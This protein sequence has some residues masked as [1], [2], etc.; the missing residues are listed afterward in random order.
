MQTASISGRSTSN[1]NLCLHSL[2][3][4]GSSR[5]FPAQAFIMLEKGEAFAP[6]L[7]RATALTNFHRTPA[8]MLWDSTS[9]LRGIINMSFARYVLIAAFLGCP[10]ASFAQQ[11][12]PPFL[13][14][15]RLPP[16]DIPGIE[17][18]PVIM[19][20]DSSALLL[21]IDRLEGQLRS[22]TGQM[23]QMQFQQRKL[24]EAIRKMQETGQAA[25]LDPAKP[26]SRPL[27]GKRPGDAFDPAQNPNAPGAPRPLGQPYG[28][29]PAPGAPSAPAP[30]LPPKPALPQGPIA[31][32][33]NDPN[34]P[35][36]INGGGAGRPPQPGIA[37]PVIPVPLVPNAPAPGQQAQVPLAPLPADD[38]DQG[39][40]L[41]KQGQYAAAE[42]RLNAFLQKN[43][44]DRL[45]PEA[46]FNL[47]ETF[48]QRQRHREAAEQFLK[49]STD[50]SKSP[51]APDGLVR[52][53]MSL[54]AMG[55]KEQACATFG[56]VARKYPTAST[57]IRG[58]S[59]E[60]KRAQC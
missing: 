4:K 50:Y 53:G 42:A 49:L 27:A 10:A 40:A 54:N 16:A 6:R 48:F 2:L 17:E 32:D 41:L 39:I 19:A 55:A 7:Q 47:G 45:V 60:S 34:K 33:D 51:R 30:A 36:D 20:Q 18:G 11:Q 26:A 14:A 59:R 9:G 52:L 5:V 58:A 29:P 57:A 8:A 43:P 44:R 22:M 56:E 3:A 46:V 38:Y 1:V 12:S 21:R 25:P 37:A 35:L 31:I 13:L 15:Q 23:E 24:E 28:L